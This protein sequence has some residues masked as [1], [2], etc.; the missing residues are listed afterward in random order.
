MRCDT[1]HVNGSMLLFP[2]HNGVRDSLPLI[3]TM[4]HSFLPLSFFPSFS[5]GIP[6]LVRNTAMAGSLTLSMPQNEAICIINKV[7]THVR[8]HESFEDIRWLLIGNSLWNDEI[9]KYLARVINRCE[10][11]TAAASP[12]PSRKDVL[13]SLNRSFNDS[14][15]VA[16]FLGDLRI[17]H[18]T[19]AYSRF[20]AALVVNDE[21]LRTAIIAFESVW[22]SQFWTP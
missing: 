18:V 9:Q 12:F 11:C 15:C 16:H 3:D 13:A 19:D 10:H 17:I 22:L 21:T 4:T 14:V 8:G 7:H 6:T 20:S 2:E 1:V 5:G